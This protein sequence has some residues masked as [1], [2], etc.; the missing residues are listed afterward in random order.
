[1]W[2]SEHIGGVTHIGC[3][4]SKYHNHKGH[5]VHLISCGINGGLSYRVGEPCEY[6]EDID[7]H[8]DT[9]YNGLCI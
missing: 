9:I 6:C 7:K 4:I 2:L 5:H 8:C 3:A 1:M